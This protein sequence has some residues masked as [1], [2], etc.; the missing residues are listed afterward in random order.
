MII[1]G[2]DA[3]TIRSQ[4]FLRYL[5]CA[6]CGLLEV[7]PRRTDYKIQKFEN[8]LAVSKETS[9]LQKTAGERRATE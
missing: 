5:R 3:W 1:Y 9:T 6:A 8:V 7:L 2:A 4:D